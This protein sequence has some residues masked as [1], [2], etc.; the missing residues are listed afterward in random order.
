MSGYFE[1][2]SYKYGRH[3]TSVLKQ[4]INTHKTITHKQ[5]ENRFLLKCKNYG[6][7]PKHIT[8]ITINVNKNF[9]KNNNNTH[10]QLTN[11]LNNF[12]YKILKLEISDNYKTINVKQKLKTALEKDLKQQLTEHEYDEFMNIQ[13]TT[14]Y[15]I[16]NAREITHNNKFDRLL[17]EFKQKLGIKINHDWIINHTNIHFPEECRWILSLGQKFALPTQ[18]NNIN[19]INIIADFEQC[20]SHYKTEK[21]KETAREILSHNLNTNIRNNNTNQI[22]RY[23]LK[24]YDDTL[25]IMKRHKNEIIITK[26]D[27]GNKTV[28]LYKKDYI[29]KM[30][31]LLDDKTTYKPIRTDPTD[32]LMRKNNSIVNDLYNKKHI[33]MYTKARLTCNAA[34]APQLYGQ[35]KIHK[36]DVPMRPISASYELPAYNI[37]KY[38][39]QILKNIIQTN[40]N[41]KNAYQ[42]KEQIQHIPIEEDDMLISLDV[43]SLFTNVPTYLAIKIIIKKWETIKNHTD[44]PKNQFIHILEFCLKDNNYF[45]FNN[46]IYSQNY[47]MP[48]GNPLS[49]I[50][51]GIV[52]DD[53]L[54][55]TLENLITQN[56]H[57]KYITKYVD[58]FFAIIKQKDKANIVK[59]FNYYHNKLKFTL[60]EEQHNRLNFLDTTIHKLDNK[61]ILNWY[62]KDIS[63]G[64]IINFYS[65]HDPIQKKNT[66]KNIIKKALDISDEKFHQN[67]INKLT[68][69][70]TQNN[71]PHKYINHMIKLIIHENKNKTQNT[72]TNNQ[73]TNPEDTPKTFY[74][75]IPFIPTLTNRKNIRNM[76]NIDNLKIASRPN[77]TLNRLFNTQKTKTN[78]QKQHNVVYQINCKGN[79]KQQCNKIYIGQTKRQ[80]DIRMK[81]HKRTIEL[82][83]KTT[84]LAQHATGNNHSFDFDNITILEKETKTNK[85]LTLE[86]LHIKKNID[87]A[88]NKKEDSDDISNTYNIN[89]TK[90]Q[91]F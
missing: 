56:I 17:N 77:Q 1:H 91:D 51:A 3:T 27:K 18:K 86:S 89:L 61:L 14:Q 6:I 75:S 84:A 21:E 45:K 52:L 4:Y 64:R 12:H 33:D 32:K 10:K 44:I 87:K 90:R 40:Y 79:N 53:L 24:I 31:S 73:P 54:E 41:I 57:V 63:S 82:K 81:E 78:V 36:P 59:E 55:Y 35:P 83:T 74:A 49:P 70:L 46:K 30:N 42:L 38:M 80:V 7:Y 22:D 9:N 29:D 60:E 20:F 76:I 16:K 39:G 67:N 23:I 19:I 25:R 8:N 50:I 37:S 85:R 65:N 72:Q 68:N 58:D 66:I 11:I 34:N 13:L 15:N 71:Y 5:T 43:V 47:G 2:I 48:M 88:V 28:I 26:S 62:T 69:I